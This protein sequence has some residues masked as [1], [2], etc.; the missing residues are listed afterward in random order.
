MI[1]ESAVICLAAN[2][3][4]EARN[5]F[6]PGQ[7]A[8]ALVTVNRTGKDPSKV[9]KTVLAPHQFSWTTKGIKY[10]AGKPTMKR[11]KEAEAWDRSVRIAEVV[12]S[13]QFYDIT[14]G[15][16]FYHTTQ[17]KPTWS[18]KFRFIATLGLHKFYRQA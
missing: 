1:L 5:Q 4:H 16:K 9:C 14:D 17:V 7:Y 12:L 2:I 10:V 11:P 13:G 8:V 3:Y 6:I 15:A 18:E